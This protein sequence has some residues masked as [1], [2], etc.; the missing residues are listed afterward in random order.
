MEWTALT[1]IMSTHTI[2]SSIDDVRVKGFVKEL[3]CIEGV[4]VFEDCA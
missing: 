2:N 3:S 1:V 4:C